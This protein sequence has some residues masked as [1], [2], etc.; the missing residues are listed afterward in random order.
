[1]GWGKSSPTDLSLSVADSRIL[2]ETWV[3]VLGRKVMAPK[4]SRSIQL[5]AVHENK[6][7][8]CVFWIVA[9]WKSHS[10][11]KV[12]GDALHSCANGLPCEQ[13]RG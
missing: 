6:R 5:R 10:S 4:F 3:M 8:S 11:V 7:S 1:M 2:Q 13:L 12:G 9:V